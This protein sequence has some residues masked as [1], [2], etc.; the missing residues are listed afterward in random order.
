MAVDQISF[1]Q[2]FPTSIFHTSANFLGGYLILGTFV[3]ILFMLR[4]GFGNA[5]PT[6]PWPL[7][8]NPIT[9]LVRRRIRAWAYL[10][11]GP[12]IIEESYKK[13]CKELSVP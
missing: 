4:N 10:L 5:K 11:N 13:V 9:N 8:Q 2:P 6:S 3:L 7:S 1:A 12:D